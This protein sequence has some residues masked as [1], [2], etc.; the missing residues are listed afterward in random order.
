MRRCRLFGG[1]FNNTIEQFIFIVLVSF[2][3]QVP[4]VLAQYDIAEPEVYLQG[5]EEKKAE[6]QSVF[7][8]RLKL[9]GESSIS[10][11]SILLDPLSEQEQETIRSAIERQD[12]TKKRKIGI[13]R[14]VPSPYCDAIDP[15][16]YQWISL[17]E[18]GRAAVFS[19]KS[20]E[21]VALRAEIK[22]IHM[23]KG[24]ELRFY[25][26]TNPEEVY[27]PY[28]IDQIRGQMVD[29]SFWSPVIESDSIAIEI[30][31]PKGLDCDDLSI[32]IPQ[33]SH[34]WSSVLNSCGERRLSE[35]SASGYCNIDIACTDW[36]GSYEERSVAKMLFTKGGST[37]ACTGTALTDKDPSTYIP[38][39][40]TSHHCISTQAAASSL[41][42]YWNFQKSSCYGPNPSTVTQRTGGAKLLSTGSSTDYTLLRLYQNLPSGTAFAGWTGATVN[43][44]S[45]VV[46]IHHPGGD[47]KK[48]S[49][50]TTQQGFYDCTGSGDGGLTCNPHPGDGTH[51]A[52][53]WYDGTTEAGSSGSAL[54]DNQ[55]HVIGSLRGGVASCQNPNG[56]DYYG[57]FDLTYPKVERWLGGGSDGVHHVFMWCC[58]DNHLREWCWTCDDG[59]N[60]Y[61]LTAIPWGKEISD[62][63]SSF[64]DNGI[65]HVFARGVDNHLYEWWWTWNDGWNISDLT[66]IPWG[67]EIS[68]APSSFAADGVHHV[69]AS[70]VDG[71]LYE[72]C[73]TWDDGWNIS[74][75]TA[76]PWGK[77]ISDVPSSFT[78]N[79]IHHV[80]ARGVDGHLYEWCWTWDDGWN[81]YDL[82]AIPWGKEISDVPSSFTD[83]G[84]HHVFA[85]GV[86]GHLYEWC[87]T[88]N[89][90]WNI[91][92]LTAIPWGKEVLDVPLSFTAD[93]VHHVFAHGVDGYL[94]EWWCNNGWSIL[95]LDG[96]DF[97]NDHDGY[98]ENQG[99]CN[100]NDP[101][102]HPNATE[103]CRDGIDQD[104]WGG[105][106]HDCDNDGDGYPE[107]T[108]C[109]DNDPTIH[110]NAT[111]ICGDGID[112]DCW[113]GDAECRYEATLI[114][115]N[116]Y[117]IT[118]RVYFDNNPLGLVSPHNTRTWKVRT[119]RHTV[120]YCD[121]PSGANCLSNSIYFSNGEIYRIRIYSRAY[122]AREYRNLSHPLATDYALKPEKSLSAV[123]EGK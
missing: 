40:L 111:D 100:D 69:F 88:W 6:A 79:G 66:A 57:R 19:V 29:D 58:A 32:A 113:E 74:D 70:G 13:G 20:S 30:F 97:D 50:G 106:L 33:V 62:V 103:I 119:G 42:T 86:D 76:I 10:V 81:I 55:G 72:W 112:Q 71:H 75:L 41:I 5:V 28:L 47:L 12:T 27:G 11:T 115:Q 91:Y 51:I 17:P 87:W 101:T 2:L 34:L 3:V 16:L 31:L 26:P 15:G 114:V 56:L 21:A 73:W 123:R 1:H 22:I 35:I 23:P 54:F 122:S 89:D 61:D 109:N 110:P 92:D 85:R 44:G 104:C 4:D 64:T 117:H 96:P 80:F 94:Y 49:F 8:A 25:N 107:S 98:T 99:D 65:H 83:N 53:Q 90:G 95:V 43:Y 45:K 46:G 68:D 9:A 18:G 37:Y 82:T 78:D 38:Y 116:D 7:R 118:Q 14:S 93:G 36:K 102:I 105:D 59:W 24:A 63:P 77:E 121:Y 108:D 67:K 120:K 39:F 48:I 84:I 60:I 52:I